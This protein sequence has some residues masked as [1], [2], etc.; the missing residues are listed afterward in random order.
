MKKQTQCKKRKLIEY[1][2]KAQKEH[3]LMTKREAEEV[4]NTRKKLITN[5]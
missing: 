3:K 1:R 4:Y 5:T 2:Y